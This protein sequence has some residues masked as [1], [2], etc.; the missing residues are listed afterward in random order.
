MDFK[1]Y[2]QQWLILMVGVF[3]ASHIIPGIHYET[4]GSLI[5]VVLILSFLNLILRPILIL[6]TLP[7]VI[8]T[9]GVGI[10]VINA[11]LFLL[12]NQMV[13][14]FH[15]DGFWAAFFGSI[16]VSLIGMVANLLLA[17]PQVQVDVRRPD[18]P[19]MGAQGSSSKRKLKD[20]DV[21]DI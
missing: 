19:G 13:S 11:F 5:A 2:L 18:A 10:L 8:L 1:R 20:D 21:I 12:V 15:V 4:T 17:R 3:V 16:V 7:F 14:G 9:M 6:F